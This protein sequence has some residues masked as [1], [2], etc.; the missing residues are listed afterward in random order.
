MPLHGFSR[1]RRAPRPRLYEVDP[2]P[3]PPRWAPPS[4]GRRPPWGCRPAAL[5]AGRL[6]KTQRKAARVPGA[7]SRPEPS[8]SRGKAPG[9]GMASGQKDRAAETDAWGCRAQGAVTQAEGTSVR[10]GSNRKRGTAESERQTELQQARETAAEK[11]GPLAER[12]TGNE[13]SSSGLLSAAGSVFNALFM[14][15]QSNSKQ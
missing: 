11:A 1:A 13:T 7:V 10:R 9:K 5:L 6:G 12:H 4:L 3:I 2:E 8:R 14:R 15:L